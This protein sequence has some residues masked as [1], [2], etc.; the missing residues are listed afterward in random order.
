MISPRIVIPENLRQYLDEHH[1]AYRVIEHPARPTALET[2]EA[3]HVSGRRLAKTVLLAE[4]GGD[5]GYVLAILPADERVDLDRLG[6]ALGRPVELA[7]ERDLELL[8]PGFELGA[9]PPLRELVHMDVVADACLAGDRIAFNGGTHTDL[10]EM[11][12]DDFRRLVGP[13]V[14]D[15]GARAGAEA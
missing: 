5:G 10:V 8:F 9:V 14:I 11:R 15:I 2:A 13:R 12:W 6:L 1:V 7:S 4:Q 3:A